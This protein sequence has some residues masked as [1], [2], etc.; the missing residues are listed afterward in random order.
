MAEERGNHFDPD[1]VEVFEGIGDSF[2][3]IYDEHK[4]ADPP[5]E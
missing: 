2:A 1:L 3:R 5:P 4:D